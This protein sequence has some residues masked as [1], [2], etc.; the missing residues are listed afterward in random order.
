LTTHLNH[1]PLADA[2][3]VNPTS[4]AICGFQQSDPISVASQL[5]RRCEPRK[6][7]THD[8]DIDNFQCYRDI[9]LA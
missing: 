1:L 2:H 6:S 7:R 8:D 9:R 3:T 5:D 4:D